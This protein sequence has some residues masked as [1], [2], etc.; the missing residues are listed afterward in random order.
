MNE[1]R[2]Q[3]CGQELSIDIE[4]LKI[5]LVERYGDQLFKDDEVA[6]SFADRLKKVTCHL[7]KIVNRN[8]KLF[9]KCPKTY[10]CKE[11]ELAPPISDRDQ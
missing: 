11:A 8:Q 9:V 5:G 1:I 6:T 3:K 10:A 7:N 2:L 4:H